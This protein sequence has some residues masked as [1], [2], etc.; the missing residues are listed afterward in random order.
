MPMD[1][2]E[3]LHRPIKRSRQK[4]AYR[5]RRSEVCELDD[6]DVLPKE[7]FQTWLLAYVSPLRSS[8]ESLAKV[9]CTASMGLH[10]I[11]VVILG[12]QTR[13]N[14]KGMKA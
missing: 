9:K 2:P 12:H 3:T 5:H 4:S 14:S 11:G 7:H 6:F 13:S 1:V 8:C 10:K